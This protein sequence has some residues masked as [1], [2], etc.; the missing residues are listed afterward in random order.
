[1]KTFGACESGATA[2]EYTLIACLISIVIVTGASA[3]GTQL[4]SVFGS[5][6]FGVA[7]AP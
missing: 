2:I 1:M 7:A 5:I 6:T 3:I 4:N